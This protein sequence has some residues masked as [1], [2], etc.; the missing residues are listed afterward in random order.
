MTTPAPRTGRDPRRAPAP[1]RGPCRATLTVALAVA[2]LLPA[3]ALAHGTERG[4]VLLL[5]GG[6]AMV[7]GA[8]VVAATFA[9]LAAVPERRLRRLA[10]ARR[11]LF[12]V[13]RLP[14][15]PVSLMA[16]VMLAALVLAGW[17]GAPDPLRNPLPLAVWTLG[18]VAFTQVQALTGSLWPWL[19]PWTGP[20]ALLRRAGIGAAAP[21]GAEPARTTPTPGTEARFPLAGPMAGPGLL[22]LPAGCGHAPAIAVFFAFAWVEIVS[23]APDDPSRLAGRVAAWWGLTLAALLVFGRDWWARGEPFAIYFGL[24]GRLSPL[25]VE[26]GR[27]AV[28]WPGRQLCQAPPLPPS[29]ILFVLLVLGAASFD[30]LAETFAWL[31]LWGVNPLEF[32][33]RSGVTWPNTLGLVALP[34]AL[35]ALFALTVLL[36]ARLAGE[37]G[38]ARQRHLAGR[39]VHGVVPIAIAFQGAH[40]LPFLLMN[41]QHAWVMASDPLGQGWDLFG[42][43]RHHVTGSFLTDMGRLRWLWSAQIGVVVAGHVIGVLVAHL[44]ALDEFGDARR[45]ALS[46]GPLALAM[47]GYTVF[48]LWLLS[49]PVAG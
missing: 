46:Q 47:V 33:G 18:W 48:G 36:G 30:G 35:A 12:R 19:N 27:L 15:A 13:G 2:L 5:P 32:P 24:V 42:T 31:A 26:R 21:P 14:E 17:F 41:A 20:L 38:R 11:P 1:A 23:L 9:L 3:P 8:A 44:V 10:R 45:A 49:T 28:T 40:Y 4:L 39:L 7:A 29:G 6:A 43:A 16:F 34:G 25:I 22:R 37:R